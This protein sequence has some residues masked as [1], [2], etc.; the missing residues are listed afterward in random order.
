MAPNAFWVVADSVE[1]TAVTVEDTALPYRACVGIMVL[2][3]A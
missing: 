1:P 2:N 3:R